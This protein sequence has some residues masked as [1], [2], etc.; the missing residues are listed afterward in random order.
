MYAFFSPLQK[1]KG[2]PSCNHNETKIRNLKSSLP[3]ILSKLAGWVPSGR[4]LC[5]LIAH[6]IEYKFSLTYFK[7]RSTASKMD[8]DIAKS[9][10]F[11]SWIPLSS[12]L[13]FA[14]A[15]FKVETTLV[16]R[17]HFVIII[18]ATI[19]AKL[20]GNVDLPLTYLCSRRRIE[21]NGQIDI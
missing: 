11:C 21:E 14:I 7:S 6:F 17:R 1:E 16:S 15:S 3:A 19:W 20:A 13:I 2:R 4:S 5:G 10:D 9:V 8:C 12:F 18:W